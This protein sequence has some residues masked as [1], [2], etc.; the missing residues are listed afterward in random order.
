MRWNKETI[1]NSILPIIIDNTM[2]SQKEYDSLDKQKLGIPSYPT[3]RRHYGSILDFCDESNIKPYNISQ[4]SRWN[5]NKI[6]EVIDF[7]IMPNQKD[8]YA[9]CKDSKY[10]TYGTI[11]K[12]FGTIKNFCLVAGII[13]ISE[14]PNVIWNKKNIIEI[15]LPL[16]KNNIMLSQDEYNELKK[17][18]ENIPGYSVIWKN[19]GSIE[20][21]CKESG[22]EPYYS[23]G[24][25]NSVFER[26]V[27][28]Y[29]LEIYMG[30]VIGN[31]T[32]ILPNMKEIDIFIPGLSLG[33]E[34]NGNY[35]HSIRAPKPKTSEYHINKTIEAKE[36]G[37]TLIHIWESEWNENEEDIKEY[38][39][40]VLSRKESIAMPD[41]D[42][43]LVMD[44]MKPILYSNVVYQWDTEPELVD[45]GKEKCW[46]C[47][48]TVYEVI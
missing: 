26:S 12:H 7:D 36:N 38:L 44:N 47:G 25:T 20:N 10:P 40:L 1:K 46:N 3:I 45:V 28:S 39:S 23:G 5:K 43:L 14:I 4:V 6:I 32:R 15:V 34:C 9:L 18:N 11:R 17:G 30:D 16:L 8:Y 41:D 33:I 2:Y 42:G 29:I 19:F 48:T 24:H 22:I 35:W 21:F 37:I 27:I 31:D 13:D